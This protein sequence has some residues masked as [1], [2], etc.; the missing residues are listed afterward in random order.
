MH[1][2]LKNTSR[3]LSRLWNRQL[4]VFFFFLLLS[5]SFW[6]FIVGKEVKEVDI[7]VQVTLVGTPDDVVITTPPPSTVT[8]RLRDETFT[9]M[10]YKYRQSGIFHIEVNWNDIAGKSPHTHIRLSMA[11][12]L[13]PLSTRLSTT[14]T[15]VGRRPDTYDIYFNHGQSKVVATR[16]AGNINAANDYNIISTRLDPDSVTIYAS[17]QALDTIHYVATKP[18][19]LNGCTE[20]HKQRVAFTAPPGV[21]IVPEYGTVTVEADRYVEKT[22]QVPV[23]AINCPPNTTL[24]TFPSKVSVV[25]QVGSAEYPNITETS[26][27]IVIDYNRL[28]EA[29]KNPQTGQ[30]VSGEALKYTLTLSNV[31]YGVRHPRIAP[32][33]VECIIEH[34]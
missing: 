12:V 6:L 18:F 26:F 27:D 1:P 33:E 16:L 24:H 3:Y 20:K 32:S 4:L 2:I 5:A 23:R 14:T 8:V 31:P 25:F 7:E 15:I 13:K 30:H 22:V 29:L 17:P 34:E 21:K 28:P 10:R 9:L 11:D 19:A